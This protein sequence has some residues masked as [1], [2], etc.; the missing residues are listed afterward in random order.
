MILSY[1]FLI[2]RCAQTALQVRQLAQNLYT[3]RSI[4]ETWPGIAKGE[5]EA[6]EHHDKDR[7]EEESHTLGKD[8]VSVCGFV[9]GPRTTTAAARPRSHQTQPGLLPARCVSL[10]SP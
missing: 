8:T 10:G 3:C 9:L 2:K 4:G 6:T 5:R 7:A 1:S